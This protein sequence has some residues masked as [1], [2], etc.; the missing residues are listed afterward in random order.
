MK[1]IVLNLAALAVIAMGGTYL[2]APLAAEPGGATTQAE[3]T[4]NGITV[5]GSS[6]TTDGKTCSCTGS[7]T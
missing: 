3:C 2:A 7:A 6:C 5:R 4:V 1:K